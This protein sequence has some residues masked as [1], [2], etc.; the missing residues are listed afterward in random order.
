L[1]EDAPASAPV[2]VT[3]A[4]PQSLS[5]VRSRAQSIQLSQTHA[6]SIIAQPQSLADAIALLEHKDAELISTKK[7]L[8]ACSVQADQLQ[9][10]VVLAT[11]ALSQMKAAVESMT[12]AASLSHGSS[13][14]S[15][16]SS[17][18]VDTLRRELA[19]MSDKFDVAERD[20]LR[21][22]EAEREC[23]RLQK[24]VEDAEKT[25]AAQKHDASSTAQSLQQFRAAADEKLGKAQ[26][27]YLESQSTIAR[28][29]SQL[30]EVRLE[31][32]NAELSLQRL[33]AE[34]ASQR[35]MHSQMQEHLQA[36][37]DEVQEKMRAY[38]DLMGQKKI[39]DQNLTKLAARDEQQKREIEVLLGKV[40]TLTE[41]V[42]E[43]QPYRVE[44]ENSRRAVARLGD[45]NKAF[46]VQLFDLQAEAQ[47]VPELLAETEKL[48]S[49]LAEALNF[50]EQLMEEN[51]QLKGAQ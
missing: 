38:L 24:R 37:R 43:L 48:K 34:T 9:R 5:P 14:T 29:E 20:A 46:K 2:H 13:G 11:R 4:L 31:K 19:V 15:T 6:S 26:R 47:K 32:N 49:E 39:A 40:E 22:R 12:A 42:K 3:A 30:Q 1:S 50:T 35:S 7:M 8:D 16:V 23:A 36:A 25:A 51:E 28:L 44:A 21:A 41:S 17:V 33:E 10:Q 18:E 45:E 27:E